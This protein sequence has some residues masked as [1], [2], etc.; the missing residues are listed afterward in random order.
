MMLSESSAM[1][2]VCPEG[3]TEETLSAWRD[4]MLPPEQVESLVR[5]VDG[6]EA[7]RQA[8]DNFNTIAQALQSQSVPPIPS[9]PKTWS[10]VQQGVVQHQRRTR[11]R[12]RWLIAVG[13]VIAAFVTI[14]VIVV[15]I[16]IP[17]SNLSVG[18]SIPGIVVTPTRVSPASLSHGNIVVRSDLIPD[19]TFAFADDNGV[20]WEQKGNAPKTLLLDSLLRG[21]VS[22]GITWAPDQS[23][24]L[25]TAHIPG[26]TDKG[27]IINV[28]TSE[29]TPFLL[30]DGSPLI[31]ACA[32]KGDGS[33]G[34]YWVVDRYILYPRSI[35][36]I[37]SH[38]SLYDLQTHQPV[39][40]P[41]DAISIAYAPQVRGPYIYYIAD[42]SSIISVYDVVL[43]GTRAVFTLPHTVSSGEFNVDEGGWR[44][45]SD[46]HTV[47]YVLPTASSGACTPYYVSCKGYLIPS[48]D[49]YFSANA[50]RTIIEAHFLDF[51]LTPDGKNAAAILL[52]SSGTQVL[53]GNGDEPVTAYP[54][55]ISGPSRYVI[56]G[57]MNSQAGRQVIVRQVLLDSSNRATQTILYRFGN[58]VTTPEVIAQMAL[59]MVVFAPYNGY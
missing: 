2:L 29:A 33:T 47:L 23:R 25:V 34:C 36:G 16:N 6:C 4:N 52:N 10:A 7:C 49:P 55:G 3:I 21:Q 35:D 53:M 57:W 44:I 26:S 24:L 56:T 27:W 58:D 50:F 31:D 18:S 42:N 43:G 45:S 1:P 46:S 5:H 12:R 9:Q 11:V 17:W 22:W 32:G 59:P 19:L 39:T 8:I 14:A 28:A 48:P 37:V 15:G 20:I 30:N 51:D 54:I 40:S 38:Y 13:G 41:L